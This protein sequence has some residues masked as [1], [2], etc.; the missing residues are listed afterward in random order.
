MESQWLDINEYS[1]SFDISISTIRRYI[2]K[3]KLGVRREK[4]KYL[5]KTDV[6]EL[7]DQG[8]LFLR[9]EEFKKKIK[10][11]QQEIYELKMLINIYEKRGP[12]S[13]RN[14]PAVIQG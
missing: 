8:S 11:L 6:K 13:I 14:A 5:I 1:R 12:S 3:G 4:G 9:N 10:I 7:K 2:K